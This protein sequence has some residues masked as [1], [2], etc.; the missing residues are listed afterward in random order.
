MVGCFW[1]G[2]EGYGREA[3]AGAGGGLSLPL[4]TKNLFFREVDCES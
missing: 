4:E 2:C 3:V 1:V